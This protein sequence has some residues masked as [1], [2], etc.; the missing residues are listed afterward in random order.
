MLALQDL[1]LDFTQLGV[2]RD[3]LYSKVTGGLTWVGAIVVAAM[4]AGASMLKHRKGDA[5]R[6][7]IVRGRARG[8][9]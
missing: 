2:E 5:I 3:W 6:D 9:A 4:A 8:S 7:A 1:R